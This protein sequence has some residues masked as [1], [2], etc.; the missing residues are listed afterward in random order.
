MCTNDPEGFTCSCFAAPLAYDL[1]VWT[2][3][4]NKFDCIGTITNLVNFKC[5]VFLCQFTFA[6][7]SASTGVHFYYMH[8]LM[9]CI[10]G[11]K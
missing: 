10:N 1:P 4:E 7:L 8:V 5:C 9:T 11:L 2:L 6:F 3:S